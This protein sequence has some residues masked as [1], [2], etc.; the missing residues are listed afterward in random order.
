[1]G[2][3]AARQ[4][5]A[6]GILHP[7]WAKA[8]V[9]EEVGGQRVVLVTM[10]LLG[11]NFGRELADQVRERAARQTGIHTDHMLFNFSHTHCG[12][13]SSVNDGALVTYA[14]DSEQQAKVNAY[15]ITL[16]DKLVGLISSA[17]A[18]LQPAQLAYATGR[19][20]FASNRRTRYNPD[21]PV[22]HEV[23][24]LRVTGQG[25]RLLAVLFGYACHNTTLGGSL[26]Q[27]NG[28]YAGF[29][30]IAFEQD[31]AGAM[32]MFMMGCGGDSNPAP[33]GEV[34]LAEQ[35]GAALA[36]AA[37][38]VLDGELL[39]L[40][41]PLKVRFDRID[42]S[43]VDPPT[44]LELE[45]RRGQGNVYDQ[46]LTEILLRRVTNGESLPASYPFPVH[47]VRFGKSLSLIALAGE[48]VVDYALRLRK[49]MAD[50]RIWVAGYCN[51]VFAYVPSERVLAEGGYEGGGAM[52]YFGLHGPFQPGLE[53]RIVGLAHELMAD[54]PAE[55]TAAVGS[56]FPVADLD[57]L[58]ESFAG[59]LGFYARDLASGATYAWHAHDRFPPASA[60]KLPVMIQLYRQS[61][62]G[63]VDLQEKRRLPADISTHGTGPLARRTD[64]V[65]MSLEDYCRLMIINSDNMATDLLIRVVGMDAVNGSS[66]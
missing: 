39:P 59:R 35:H 29:A 31:H 54:D 19:A 21:G 13:V 2:G 44:Q 53:D 33:R 43:F 36:A 57:R 16:T 4:H 17:A 30:Q 8:L 55:G 24:V 62:A 3:F 14:L 6:T 61:V 46:R 5:P 10:D 37:A 7:L 58:A 52:K 51:E 12:P 45:G 42:L 64:P 65:E 50:S 60:I 1:M 63:D 66:G 27:Y 49:D 9:I 11:D 28:D 22:D 56:P 47:V 26:D 48:T 40:Q 15:T 18:K 20:T 25:D 23:P 38:Q 34:A 41:G 32:A